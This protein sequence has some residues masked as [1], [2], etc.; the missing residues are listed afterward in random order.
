MATFEEFEFA[1]N[2]DPRCPVALVLDCSSSMGEP[3][4]DGEPAPIVALNDGLD[5]LVRELHRD[6]LARRRV[7]LSVITFGTAVTPATPFATVDNLTLPTLV[8]SGVTKM[9]E[10]LEVALDALEERKRSYRTNG[11]PYYRPW[12]LLITD[13]LPTDDIAPAAERIKAAETNKSI[14]FFPV[15]ID[16]ADFDTLGQLGTR[17]PLKLKGLAFDELFVWLS[18]SQSRVSASNP[19]DAVALPAPTG[20]AEV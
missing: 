11:I 12:L 13:G 15:G 7:E 18:A 5:V 19:G 8:P 6:P 9:G 2:P 3:L 20:W 14:A 4:A 10:A 1:D 16:G 17:A